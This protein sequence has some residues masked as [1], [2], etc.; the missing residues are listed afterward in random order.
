MQILTN[1]CGMPWS[2][3]HQKIMDRRTRNDARKRVSADIGAV[4]DERIRTL[5]CMPGEHR[6]SH[7]F[8]VVNGRLQRIPTQ[9]A[10]A[11]S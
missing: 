11:A 4:I 7:V 10:A 6:G 1:G 3:V 5:V 2:G 8:E 9:S